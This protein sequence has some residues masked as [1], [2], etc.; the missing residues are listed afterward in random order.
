[1]QTIL[2][3]DIIQRIRLENPWWG[4]N[5]T[6]SLVHQAFKPRAYFGLFFPLVKTKS[7][8]RAVVLMGPRRVGKT[9]MIYHAVQALLADGVPPESICYF[10]V[11]HPIYKG[12]SIDQLLDYYGQASGVDYKSEQIYIFFDEIQYLRKWEVHLKSIVDTLRVP[13][14]EF[15]RLMPPSWFLRLW[16]GPVGLG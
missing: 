3:E 8:R 6:T 2:K 13:T 7:V 12:L 9:V 1:M 16:T 11:D 14:Y 4:G 10:S 5:H 15:G